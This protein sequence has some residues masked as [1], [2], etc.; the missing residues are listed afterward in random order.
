LENASCVI[1][2]AGVTGCSIAY[3]LA[4]K[5]MKDVILLEKEFIASKATGVCP[6]GIRQQ[7]SS[8]LGCLLS[9]ASVEF[10]KK[11]DEEFHPEFPLPFVQ[12]GYLFL[13]YSAEV[14]GAYRQNVA[15]QNSFGIPSEIL[16]VEQIKEFIPAINTTGILGGAYCKED[17]YLEDCSGFTNTLASRAR[18]MGVR[19]IYDEAMEILLEENQVVGVRGKK[20]VYRC[21]TIVNVA[22]CDAGPL[23]ASIGI[24]LPIVVGKRRLLYTQ[25]VEDHF[26]NPCLA[27]LEKGWGGKQLHE[28]NI[29]MAYIAEEAENLSNM[30]FV[31]RSVEL[32][33][34]IIPR[35]GETRIH[36]LQEGYYDITPDDN[37]ILGKVEGLEGYFHAVGFSGHGFMLSPAVGKAI[38][39][40]IA[41]EKPFV[42]LTEWSLNR[43]RNGMTRKESLV[44]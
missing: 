36:R 39:Q 6:G 10:L 34:D 25:R 42:D 22:G 43:F 2:G 40:L 19:I 15:L 7:W 21:E 28:G 1:I 35:L 20:G 41:G 38:A 11:L 14:L 23:A 5:K 44:L 3:H 24:H 16:S 13:A 8:R 12:S 18:T 30:E 33:T 29:Y 17:G 4:K 26:L 27:S 32:G 9:K 37:P 31:E